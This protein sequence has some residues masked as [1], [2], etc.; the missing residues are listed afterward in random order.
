MEDVHYCEINYMNRS[1]DGYFG[2]FDGHGGIQ[3]AKW[4]SQRFH[5]LLKDNIEANESKW[6]AI[7]IIAS[8][9]DK[10]DEL[11]GEMVGYDGSGTTAAIA[12]VKN[13]H[14]PNNNRQRYLYTANVGDTRM[15]ICNNGKAER[16]SKDHNCHD[17]AERQRIISNGG[18]VLHG[19]VNGMLA[20][21]RALGDTPLKPPVSSKPYTTESLLDEV[22][23]ELLIIASDGVWD[24]CTDQQAVDLIRGISDP[25]VASRTLVRH[26]INMGSIDNTSCV[27]IRFIDP[28][29]LDCCKR[30]VETPSPTSS[31]SNPLITAHPYHGHT[32]AI[33]MA[34]TQSIAQERTL[35]GRIVLDTLESANLPFSESG[36]E[37]AKENEDDDEGYGDDTECACCRNAGNKVSAKKYHRPSAMETE[38]LAVAEPTPMDRRARRYGP[39]RSPEPLLFTFDEDN[40]DHP[41]E[42]VHDSDEE[43]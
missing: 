30:T 35:S 21:T 41:S 26:A 18:V 19:R 31:T 14:I 11:V 4:C 16:V 20:I 23:D 43:E 6:Q 7:A 9:F 32:G 5:Q 17:Q 38:K 1:G 28:K 15:V 2:L 12:Y 34:V 40:D 36:P 25:H 33:P 37:Q 22:N 39:K 24:V 29:N 42:A 13:V 27:V 10:V 8:T 3:S